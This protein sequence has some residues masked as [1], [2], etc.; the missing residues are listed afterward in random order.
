[1]TYN[2]R[3]LAIY[4]GS[5]KFVMYV[6]YC[7]KSIKIWNFTLETQLSIARYYR[8]SKECS[9]MDFKVSRL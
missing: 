1:M 5:L 8:V 9:I 3:Y 6:T 2:I 4:I 7:H